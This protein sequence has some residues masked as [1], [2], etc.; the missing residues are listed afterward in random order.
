MTICVLC[1]KLSPALDD[2]LLFGVEL[3]GITPLRVQIAEEA[4]S[5]STEREIGDRSGYTDVDSNVAGRHFVLEA[6][7]GSS[8]GSEERRCIPVPALADDRNRF[9]ERIG[10]YETQHR[11]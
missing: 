10:M 11:A 8:V 1:W 9:V 7:S 4:R 5:P 6:A 2:Y 3:D